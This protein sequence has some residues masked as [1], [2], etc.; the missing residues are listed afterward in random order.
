MIK[1]RF[2]KAGKHQEVKGDTD[3]QIDR[4]I[5]K[6]RERDRQKK[7]E[8]DRWKERQM[9]RQIEIERNTVE[10]EAVTGTDIKRGRK[11]VESKR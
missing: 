5:D 2:K 6:K 3:R 11:R 4:E 8:I 9:G 1:E 7:R 10:D